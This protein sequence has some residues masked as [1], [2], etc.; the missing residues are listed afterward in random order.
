M[1]Q[2]KKKIAIVRFSLR[3]RRA[4]KWRKALSVRPKEKDKSHSVFRKQPKKRHFSSFGTPLFE[5]AVSSGSYFLALPF[6]ERN[7]LVTLTWVKRFDPLNKKGNFNVKE[8]PKNRFKWMKRFLSLLFFSRML[9]TNAFCSEN[10]F[11]VTRS[12]FTLLL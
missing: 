6:I 8:A 5:G 3:G 4:L 11:W 12:K 2:L 1:P 9:F 7:S 10:N